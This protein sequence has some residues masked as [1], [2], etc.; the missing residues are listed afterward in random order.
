MVEIQSY[1]TSSLLDRSPDSVGAQLLSAIMDCNV[2]LVEILIHEHRDYISEHIN[3]P[4][5]NGNR[6]VHLCAPKVSRNSDVA[7]SM[8]KALVDVGADLN[9]FDDIGNTPLHIM[10]RYDLNRCIDG[11]DGII[12]T[13][14]SLGAKINSKPH[15]GRTAL[16]VAVEWNKIDNVIALINNGI[17]LNSYFV[18]SGN[19]KRRGTTPLHMAVKAN[20]Y[21]ITRILL[22]S[23]A[24]PNR[25]DHL[26]FPPIYY[27]M[28]N[29]N[30]E[31]FDLLYQYEACYNYK[32]YNGSNMLHHLINMYID[33]Y[34]IVY[35][36]ESM[37]ELLHGSDN[38]GVSPVHLFFRHGSEEIIEY[39]V[40]LNV[41]YND[42]NPVD[43]CTPV[44]YLFEN[45][46]VS[47]NFAINMVKYLA[48]LG[49]RNC[50]NKAG[51]RPMDLFNN[52][53]GGTD[54]FT[55]KVTN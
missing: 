3:E 33:D 45:K 40:D 8:I 36:I 35:F 27:S 48:E 1:F 51:A 14:I 52:L 19:K 47:E 7:F 24:N 46:D 31:I 54:V 22:E 42:V 53:I 55:G 41:N 44:H 30:L 10:M 13:M 12:K 38:D 21:D 25:Q 32:L 5:Y 4:G 16:H 2:K 49:I 34:Q 39:L 29:G 17:Y 28:L 18:E 20:N 37:P 6:L 26:D 43:G 15:L 50:S 11:A 23:R 9:L